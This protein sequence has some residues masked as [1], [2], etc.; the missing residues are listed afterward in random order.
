MSLEE[1]DE[2]LATAEEVVE[3]KEVEK[4]DYSEEELE[5]ISAIV[6]RLV[7]SKQDRDTTHPEFND[8]SYV[9]IYQENERLANTYVSGKKFEGDVEIAS[10]TVE[11]KMFAV[12]SEINRLRL[13]PEIIAHDENNEEL[14]ALGQAMTDIIAVTSENDD[15]EEGK[16]LRQVELLKQ[17]TVFIEEMWAR[18]YKYEKKFNKRDIGKIKDA[19]W[20]AKLKLVFEGP[21]RRV[22]YGPG[23]YLGNLRDS[24]P[25]RNQ[26]FI[27]THKLTTYADVE[28]RYGG[29]KVDGTRLWDRFENVPNVRVMGIQSELISTEAPTADTANQRA[30]AGTINHAWGLSDIQE[31]MVEEIHYQDRFN[32]EFQIFLNGIPMLPVGFP[33]SAISPN[34][35]YTVEKQ[36]LQPINPFFA[37]GRS[38]VMKVREQS[39]ILDELLRLLILKTRKSIHPPYANL[40]NRVISSKV[41]MPGRITMGLDANALQP[42][43]AESQGATASEFEMF[44]LLQE[45]V[46]ENTVSK[47]FTGMQGK[48]GTTAFEVATLQKQA[49]KLLS[50]TIFACTML[51]MKLGYQRLFNLL[52]NYFDP[53]DTRFDDARGMIVARYRTTTRSTTLANG[54]EGVRQVIPSDDMPIPGAVRSQETMAGST[55]LSRSKAGKPALKRIYLNPTQL[56]KAKI[57]WYVDIDAQ[58]RETSNAKKL[59]FREELTDIMALIQLGSQPNV[60][61]LEKLHAVV[62]NRPSDKLFVRQQKSPALSQAMQGGTTGAR[63]AAPGGPGT[64]LPPNQAALS[65]VGVE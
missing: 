62:W 47:Q 25:I 43:G 32:D 24:G 33:L 20:D 51:E 64:A 44:K 42:I 8:K 2:M 28:A 21:R 52:E 9:E 22:L 60:P 7:R 14:T 3:S 58:P 30:N 65:A 29:K 45:R 12:L 23:V 61:E 6:R 16:L 27:F 36:I 48:S 15:G 39:D 63:S 38:F 41:L 17:G 40:S 11:Q 5:Q 37:Y 35:E 57:L 10:G 46:D 13:A 18:E 56:R 50:L 59:L 49:E 55:G 26:P 54:A 53:T 1:K 19:Q 34:G 4:P 31:G